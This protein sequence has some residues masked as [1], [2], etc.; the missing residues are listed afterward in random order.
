MNRLLWLAFMAW[1][2]LYIAHLADVPHASGLM[3]AVTL[4]LGA[5]CFVERLDPRPTTFAVCQRRRRAP[6][7]GPKPWD[8]VVPG[9]IGA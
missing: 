4:A 8:P 7:A 3:N 1:C 5:I 2:L 6:P 9:E